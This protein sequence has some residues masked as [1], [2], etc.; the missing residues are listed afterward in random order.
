MV[1]EF[2]WLHICEPFRSCAR[3]T[4]VQDLSQN[5]VA[6]LCGYFPNSGKGTSPKET[7]VAACDVLDARVAILTPL[8]AHT[9]DWAAHLVILVVVTAC[10]GS[11]GLNLFGQTQL[12]NCKVVQVGIQPASAL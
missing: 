6:S 9:Q 8:Q 10:F 7:A 11:E 12:I 2:S 5:P 1:T 3:T 4:L